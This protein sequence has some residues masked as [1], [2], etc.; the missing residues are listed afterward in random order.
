MTVRRPKGC[1]VGGRFES[2][3]ERCP[4]CGGTVH[5]IRMGVRYAVAHDDRDADC[6]LAPAML[7]DDDPGRL[8][9]R[10]NRRAAAAGWLA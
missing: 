10:W 1:P 4:F 8:L 7:V 2:S 3:W 9:E 5:G 6:I